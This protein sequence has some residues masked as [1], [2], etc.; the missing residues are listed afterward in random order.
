MK[1]VLLSR[2][3][4]TH[5]I[6]LLAYIQSPPFAHNVICGCY[7]WFSVGK[8][9]NVYQ[10]L[11]LIYKKLWINFQE[12]RLMQTLHQN[13]VLF[14]LTRCGY[15]MPSCHK[16][17]MF[18]L[19]HNSFTSL[20]FRWDLLHG[21]GIKVSRNSVRVQSGRSPKSSSSTF[22]AT[23]ISSNIV[24]LLQLHDTI[25]TKSIFATKFSCIY[26]SKW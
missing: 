17:H 14:V 12:I 24:W 15:R 4:K 26:L 8:I 20:L 25:Q 16:T 22:S 9:L 23:N 5:F 11:W 21:H 6:I 1:Y 2:K 13:A 7:V 18:W 19:Y 10:D 3:I